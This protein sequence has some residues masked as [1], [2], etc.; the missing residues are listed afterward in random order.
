MRSKFKLKV[1]VYQKKTFFDKCQ[2]YNASYHRSS[3][4][5]EVIVMPLSILR[6]CMGWITVKQ[7]LR[8]YTRLYL[9]IN[10]VWV[11]VVTA[12]ASWLQWYV[13]C[14]RGHTQSTVMVR[15]LGFTRPIRLEASKFSS[16]SWHIYSWV[17]SCRLY[18]DVYYDNS[19]RRWYEHAG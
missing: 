10:Q 19:R 13:V 14:D 15:H 9:V 1:L 4:Y 16:V 3:L 6:N 18:V 7:L 17:I 12:G 11:P 2:K 5:Q 8:S